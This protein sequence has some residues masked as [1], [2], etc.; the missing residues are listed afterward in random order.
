MDNFKLG[1]AVWQWHWVGALVASGSPREGRAG[2]SAFFVHAVV[3]PQTPPPRD[4]QVPHPNRR[5]G[6]PGSFHRHIAE[7]FQIRTSEGT[8]A[9]SRDPCGGTWSPPVLRRVQKAP[10]DTRNYQGP[11]PPSAGSQTWDKGKFGHS[12]PERKTGVGGETEGDQKAGP[13]D[14]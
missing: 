10:E 3:L 5:G 6:T 12:E 4:P 7:I 11:C 8:H 14:N 13:S 1:R 2:T 9:G